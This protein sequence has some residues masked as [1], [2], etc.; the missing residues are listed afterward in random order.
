MDYFMLAAMAFKPPYISNLSLWLDAA[1]ITGLNDDDKVAQ[2]NDLSGNGNNATQATE[3][4]K[5]TYKVN[6]LN[7]RPVVRCD[8]TDDWMT[9]SGI[10]IANAFT[11]FW[12]AKTAALAEARLLYNSGGTASLNRDKLGT[13]SSKMF[14]RIVD[15]GS[16]DNTQS[17]LS[18]NTY[19]I[20]TYKRDSSN[21]IDYALNGAAFTRLFSDAAQSGNHIFKELFT[22]NRAQFGD[23]RVWNGDIAELIVYQK[24][25]TVA[26]RTKVEKYLSRKW[27]IAIS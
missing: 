6:I 14:I 3:A 9:L 24:A 12:V 10:T 8:G 4:A 18:D 15:D 11:V 20:I 19:G 21:K 13:V 26:E 5:P 17:F 1:R 2:W 7:S 25:L 27:G 16:S 22:D 23:T